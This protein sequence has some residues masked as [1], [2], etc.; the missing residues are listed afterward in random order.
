MN[1]DDAIALALTFLFLGWVM[2]DGWVMWE[3]R[4]R[5]N[6][7]KREP[8]ERLAEKSNDENLVG[9]TEMNKEEIEKTVT[10]PPHYAGVTVEPIQVAE[11]YGFLMGNAIKYLWRAGKKD[12]A[13]MESDLRKARFYLERWKSIYKLEAA[14]FEIDEDELFGEEN[15]KRRLAS[16]VWLLSE[17]NEYLRALFYVNELGH[18]Y[19]LPNQIIPSCVDDVLEMLSY[20]VK[21]AEESNA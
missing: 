13:A 4:D 11:C 9:K 17:Q 16:A 3:G 19:V 5:G 21:K 8:G 6:G 1:V 10:N 14:H 20:D 18:E 15:A 12:G 2:W 7:T